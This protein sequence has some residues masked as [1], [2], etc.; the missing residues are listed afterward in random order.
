MKYKVLFSIVLCY[1]SASF[2]AIAQHGYDNFKVYGD[3]DKGYYLYEKL[4]KDL[5]VKLADNEPLNVI[6]SKLVGDNQV[7]ETV[8]E[9]GISFQVMR[10]ADAKPL[11]WKDYIKIN[12]VM[13][14][15]LA[16]ES[17]TIM[18][19]GF[20]GA[21]SYDKTWYPDGWE[22]FSLAGNTLT[23]SSRIPLIWRL[24]DGAIS[25]TIGGNYKMWLN[26]EYSSDNAVHDEWLVTK[27]F[28]PTQ[29]SLLDF[30]YYYCPAFMM[31]DINNK[32][33]KEFFKIKVSTDGGNSWKT[34][35]N[36]EDIVR[37]MSIKELNTG[38]SGMVTAVWHRYKVDLSEYAGQNIRIAFQMKGRAQSVALD[39]IVVR[40]PAPVASYLP[41]QGCFRWA[42]GE[43]FTFFS[44]GKYILA[45]AYTDLTWQNL[46]NDEANS[47]SWSFEN[48][49]TLL[50]SSVVL[51]DTFPEIA[52]P[53]CKKSFPDLT[54]YNNINV[55]SSTYNYASDL[56]GLGFVQ[57]G[58]TTKY[59]FTNPDT[60]LK[61]G[62]GTFDLS[63]GIGMGLVYSDSDSCFLFGSG[64][65]DVWQK[66]K[67][68]GLVN[69]FDKPAAPY[70][71]SGVWVKAFNVAC[72]YDSKLEL[73]ICGL[74]PSGEPAEVDSIAKSVCYGSDI[75]LLYSDG[76][77]NYY[78]IPFKFTEVDESGRE[79]NKKIVIDRPI[80]IIIRG[81]DSEDF[82]S[83]GFAYQADAHD[84]YEYHGGVYLKPRNQEEDFYYLQNVLTDFYTSF[85]MT[86]DVDF[87]FM[88]FENAED[89]QFGKNG[90][91]KDIVINTLDNFKS[92][93]IENIP[94]WLS[95]E[96]VAVTNSFHTIRLTAK[97]ADIDD[98]ERNVDLS[99]SVDGV[100]PILLNVSQDTSVSSIGFEK[101]EEI[102]WSKNNGE[103]V[104]YN[105]DDYNY[106][107]IYNLSGSCVFRS[108][109]NGVSDYV[110]PEN[111]IEHG[112]YV[113]RF[114]G[115]KLSVVKIIN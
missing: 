31:W 89:I 85:L 108:Y 16:N 87:P 77:F 53:Y 28:T 43:D 63:K 15:S 51:K 18:F 92:W 32:V 44:S 113:V 27:P 38:S 10:N 17:D 60:E 41:P 68:K 76:R 54:V 5:L 24:S 19:E 39:N 65:R 20:E 58:G 99:F 82:K 56:S 114:V 1:L 12:T 4:D 8:Y 25:G 93:K 94:D 3:I 111:A 14:S 102:F 9:D 96:E 11:T 29:Y 66:F 7:L 62:A 59:L 67:L 61:F 80:A 103:I 26:Q 35:W 71:L 52:Y 2:D 95:V 107:E 100:Q 115:N 57:Y 97:A 110:L 48:P 30:Y 79:K 46:S 33:F 42:Y 104:F 45:P 64:S 49:D 83:I 88:R 78:N 86:L 22:Q 55:F 37:K 91:S 75:K 98:I 47:F 74:N 81:F 106:M 13:K 34:H 105:C 90:G 84:N 36:L 70:T 50:T 101:S 69:V 73:T 112:S 21:P 109:L 72:N 40:N 23:S 6:D